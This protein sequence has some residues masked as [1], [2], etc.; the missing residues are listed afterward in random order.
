MSFWAI[1]PNNCDGADKLAAALACFVLDDPNFRVS[2][3]S[4]S[5]DTLIAGMGQSHLQVY[6]ERIE[7][8]YPSEW[9]V[10]RPSVAFQERLSKSVNFEHQFKRMNGGPG[11]FAYVVGRMEPLDTDDGLL[12]DG[13]CARLD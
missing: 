13:S 6:V 2:P 1:A 11:Q 12:F 7:T 10:G 3:E 8:A 4:N 9:I 5:G